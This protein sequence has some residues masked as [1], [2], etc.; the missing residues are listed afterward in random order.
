M[1][2]EFREIRTGI[3]NITV[4]SEM[5]KK[6]LEDKKI[7]YDFGEKVQKLFTESIPLIQIKK[8]QFYENFYL[9]NN[10][11]VH[12]ERPQTNR[13]TK[14]IIDTY[15]ETHEFCFRTGRKKN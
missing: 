3:L 11:T 14:P 4:Y 6:R 7:K 15:K 10:M 5:D 2:I 1:D 8:R 13:E 12:L 9:T